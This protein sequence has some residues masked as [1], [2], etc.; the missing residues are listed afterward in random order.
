MSAVILNDI[1]LRVSPFI[2]MLSA[3]MLE[4]L[5]LCVTMLS[6]LVISVTILSVVMLSVGH[7]HLLPH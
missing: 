4:V 2:A 1:M 5:V 7:F 3:F 6:V